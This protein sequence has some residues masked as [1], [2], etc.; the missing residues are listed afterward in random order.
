PRFARNDTFLYSMNLQ[1]RTLAFAN[2]VTCEVAKAVV[3]GIFI[4]FAECRI[5]ENLLDEFIDGE[6]LIQNQHAD[7]NQFGG[8][9]ADQ[10]DAQEPAV[11]ARE[12]ELEHAGSKIG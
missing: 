1:L 12:N 4:H 7:V 10:A 6:A 8:R 2:F 11:R 3:G 5:V 9:F